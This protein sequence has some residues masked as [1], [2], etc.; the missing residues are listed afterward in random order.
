M[1]F[2]LVCDIVEEGCRQ[3]DKPNLFLCDDIASMI[4][5]KNVENIDSDKDEADAKS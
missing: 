2:R 3:N 4:W 5:D 1:Y